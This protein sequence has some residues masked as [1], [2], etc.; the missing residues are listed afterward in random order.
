[1]R[2]PNNFVEEIQQISPLHKDYVGYWRELKKKCIKGVW[3]DGYW[4]PPKL[5]FYVNMN[6]IQLNKT[7]R[8]SQ[9][10]FERPF[11]RDIEWNVFYN[12]TVSR[13]FS[14]F[15]DDEEVSCLRLL[16]N[17]LTEEDKWDLAKKYPSIVSKSGQIKQYEDA[18]TYIEK[19]HNKHYLFPLYENEAKNFMWMTSRGLGKPLTK[20]TA[21]LTNEGFKPIGDV[22]L[23]EQLYDESGE[24][25]SVCAISDNAEEDIYRIK[26]SDGRVVDAS[27]DH[28]WAVEAR[29]LNSKKKALLSTKEIKED[30]KAS[31]RKDHYKWYIKQCLP[32]QYAYKP[33][34]YDVYVLGIL[35]AN[36]SLELLETDDVVIEK[37]NASNHIDIKRSWKIY[38]YSLSFKEGIESLYKQDKS[39]YYKDILYNDI[40]TRRLFLSAF[41]DLKG[42]MLKDGGIKL[43]GIEDPYMIMLLLRSL[44][45]VCYLK[46]GCILLYT[47]MPILNNMRKIPYKQKAKSFLT[48]YVYIKEVKFIGREETR[49]IEV[50]NDSHLF[51]VNDFIVTHNSYIVSSI[52]LHE[53]LFDGVSDYEEYLAYKTSEPDKEAYKVTVLVGAGNASY[54]NETLSK[55][56]ESLERLPGSVIIGKTAYPSPLSKKYKGTWKSGGEIEASYQKKIGGTWF[57]KGSKSK[58]KNKTFMDDPFA[59]QGSRNSIIVLE[60]IGMFNRLKETFNA[61]V[62]NMKHSGTFKFGTCIMI[63]T[64]GDMNGGGSLD[65]QEMFY[66]PETYDILSF[67][68][69]WE[70]KG[71]IAYFTPATYGLQEYRDEM[72][73]INE[74]AATKKIDKEREKKKRSKNKDALDS[75]IMYH[76][77]VPSEIFLNKDGNIFP[78]YELRQR[79]AVLERDDVFSYIEKRVELYYDKTAYNGVDYRVDIENRLKPINNFPFKKDEADKEGCI[80]LYELPLFDETG[81][82]PEGLYVIGHD[83]YRVDGEGE[84]LASIVVMKTK[85]YF[86][87]HGHDEIVAVYYGRPYMGRDVVNEH[88][89]KLS[90]F[91]NAK[92]YFENNVGNVKEYFE[93]KKRL[94]LLA[95]APQTILSKTATT[96][97][98]SNIQYGYTISNEKIKKEAI[99]YLRDWL[100]EERGRWEDESNKYTYGE[101]T[102]SSENNIRNL[103]RIYDRMLLKQLAGFNM[104]GNF[105]AVM[106]VIGC[107]LAM[108]ET[109]NKHDIA[110]NEKKT[111]NIN[112]LKNNKKIFKY[113]Y[114]PGT[115]FKL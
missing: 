20:K 54:V 41:I 3:S 56:K 33:L 77:L 89:L 101:M 85:K 68:D 112:F 91:Y 16:N 94:D 52:I 39:V 38:G 19:R 71:K 15:G 76:P 111:V 93:K 57:E 14:G 44:G 90:L 7:E 26:L 51:L 70:H 28:L 107:I 24:L 67:K 60:E 92:V 66:D 95:S 1:M 13:G 55:S 4:C 106:G 27:G 25:T 21:V 98:Q 65:A 113:D 8:S 17:C 81:K 88:L 11:L 96:F 103:D 40:E 43:Y 69:H 97:K 53:W 23:G 2:N 37:I 83:P 99:S 64:G 82:I 115:A 10:T 87:K 36:K 31:K 46:E 6:Y 32:I 62:E 105:D 47:N 104:K 35:L 42:K 75:F 22:V 109:Y 102:Q 79:L 86:H 58:I 29:T 45:I 74:E 5:Y 48:D 61:L 18:Q 114:V 78:V 12:F 63:G 108:E 100:L 110:S 80:V 73:N 50:S 59:G 34:N 72:G 30:L 49:C 84:S 9:K